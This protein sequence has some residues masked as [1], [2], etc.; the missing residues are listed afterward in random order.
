MD[1]LEAA[2]LAAAASAATT[3]VNPDIKINSLDSSHISGSFRDDV[4]LKESM[5]QSRSGN[6]ST[7]TTD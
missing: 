4:S 5:V 7:L 6:N 3:A 2:A 1:H